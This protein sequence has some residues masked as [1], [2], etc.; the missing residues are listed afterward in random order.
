LLSPGGLLLFTTHGRQ[1]AK[2]IRTR[3]VD[4]GLEPAKADELIADY[5]QTGF[6]YRDYPKYTL[7]YAKIESDYGVA[8]AS[9]TWVFAQLNT[10]SDLDLILASEHLWDDHQDVFAYVRT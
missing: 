7:E 9:P 3:T 10:F 8:V 1:V 2:W 5:D 4:Y 6:G